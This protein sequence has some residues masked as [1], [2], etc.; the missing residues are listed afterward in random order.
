[1]QAARVMTYLEQFRGS[2]LPCS[3]GPPHVQLAQL[4]AQ[5]KHAANVEPEVATATIL[6]MG[7]AGEGVSH[8]P[9]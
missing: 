6:A 2:Q 8:G 9:P 3:T 4:H 7:H 5:Q 1:M